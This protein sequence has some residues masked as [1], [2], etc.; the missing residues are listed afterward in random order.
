MD[1]DDVKVEAVGLGLM[2]LHLFC[3][4]HMAPK[5]PA[6]DV[7]SFTCAMRLRLDTALAL[8]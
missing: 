5:I 6:S 8:Q 7:V 1:K 3:L 2:F 4:F